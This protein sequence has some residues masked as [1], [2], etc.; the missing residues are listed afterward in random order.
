MM[1]KP[2]AAFAARRF[3][4]GPKPGDLARIGDDP[5]GWLLSQ[6]V[7]HA[8]RPAA[9]DSLPPVTERIAALAAF[10]QTQRQNKQNNVADAANKGG[11]TPA[12]GGNPAGSDLRQMYIDDIAARCAGA[13]ASDTPLVER[14]VQFW[15]NH[16]TVSAQRP[17]VAPLALNFETGAIRPHIFGRFEE[18]LL[19][20]TRHPAM[21]LYLDNAQSV[22]PMSRAG[23]QRAKGLN[24]NFA[25]ELMELQTLG[26]DG[27]YTQNDVR[28]VAKI[29][30]GWTVSGLGPARQRAARFGQTAFGKRIASNWADPESQNA[31]DGFRFLPV[32]HEPGDK[33]VLGRT[34]REAGLQ[35]GEDLLRDL[36]RH[37]AT[38]RH[39]ATKFA[40]HFIADDPP[41]AAVAALAKVYLD[42]GGDLG[43]LTRHLIGLDAAWRD[44]TPKIRTPNDWVIASFRALPMQGEEIGKRCL[45]ALRQLGQLPFQAP[46]PAGWSD[47][48]ADWLSPEALMT[49]IDLARLMA[50]RAAQTLDPRPLIGSVLGPSISAETAFQINNAPSRA[51]ALAL[52]LVSPEFMRR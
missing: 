38:A 16:F 4:L 3:G 29:L 27:G 28:E 46:S 11:A 40:R 32:A 5:R 21:L 48:G 12:R 45:A 35:E 8:S 36:A 42:S 17:V 39:I 33:T 24:E 25:R 1:G 37:P 9:L 18:M 7:P 20:S 22:G 10:R 6:I 2:D 43:E 19:A 47:M 13:V 41:A 34:Y 23:A 30:T 15:S 14:L 31:G 50:R 26:V 44:T 52:L 49:H 51:D